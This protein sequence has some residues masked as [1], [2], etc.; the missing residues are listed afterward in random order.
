MFHDQNPLSYQALLA[1]KPLGADASP[2][3][4]PQSEKV[5][6][7]LDNQFVSH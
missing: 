7:S 4:S 1:K 5:L 2:A 6:L 3:R